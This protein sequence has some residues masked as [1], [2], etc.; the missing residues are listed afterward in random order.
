MKRVSRDWAFPP[1]TKLPYWSI[2]TLELPVGL[3]KTLSDLHWGLRLSQ[4]LAPNQ[5][6]VYPSPSQCL[7]GGPKWQTTSKTIHPILSVFQVST[8][9]TW[10]VALLLVVFP[11]YPDMTPSPYN[12]QSDL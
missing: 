4:P 12:Y 1:N 9:L 11:S 2:L 7:L 5:P 6:F 8:P 3:A 10:M